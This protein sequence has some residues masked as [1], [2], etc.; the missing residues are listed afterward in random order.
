[1]ADPALIHALHRLCEARLD[2]INVL[3]QQTGDAGGQAYLLN[4]WTDP[5]VTACWKF[6]L[7]FTPDNQLRCLYKNPVSKAADPYQSLHIEF[8]EEDDLQAQAKKILQT[9][10]DY[11]KEKLSYTEPKAEVVEA[12]EPSRRVITSE[13]FQSVLRVV[14]A[15]APFTCFGEVITD[16]MDPQKQVIQ[17][18]TVKPIGSKRKET[19]Q[20]FLDFLK[21]NNWLLTQQTADGFERVYLNVIHI[22]DADEFTDK[23]LSYFESRYPDTLIPETI[24]RRA[25]GLSTHDLMES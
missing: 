2:G 12:P 14:E 24:E 19:Q 20:G 25:L 8:A 5:N 11:A 4:Y 9:L 22:K 18:G 15:V 6:Q 10:P 13:F 3:R 16:R 21:Q 7:Q 1:M 17:L 23:V